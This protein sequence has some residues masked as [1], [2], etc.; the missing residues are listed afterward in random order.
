[1]IVTGLFGQQVPAEN[2]ATV[3]LWAVWLKGVAILSALLGSPWQILSPWRTIYD[4]LTK[5]EGEP[6]SLLDRY[7]DWIGTWPA[8][9]LFLVWIGIVENLTVV[10][11][12]PQLTA[13]FLVVY[14]LVMLGGGLAFGPTWF[15]RADTL[16]VF[17]RLF[18]RIAL[19]DVVAEPDGSL[20]IYF[21]SPWN[22]CTRPVVGIAVA[23]FVIATVYT[24][25]FDG[26]TSAPGF[27]TLLFGIRNA[28]DV[29]SM[30]SIVLYLSGY[31]GFVGA[32]LGIIVLTQ[33]AAGAETAKW[34]LTA[35]AFAPTILPIAVAYEIA[36]N[37]PF[38]I[39]N[40]G[41]LPTVLWPV[42][43]GTGPE[44]DLLTWLTVVVYW[45]SQ[46]ILIVAGHIV[47]VIAAHYVAITG[48]PTTTAAR[49]GHIPLTVLMV[50]YTVLS[51]W[52]ISRPIITG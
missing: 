10:P 26:F 20:R 2:F 19:I 18:G 8:L 35:F 28:L 37:Y 29:S 22:A 16:A 36:H 30:V 14:M 38:V 32:F 52:I 33:W 48:Y 31:A 47:A 51:L 46:V 12:S 4:S 5:L 39:A 1:M 7:S 41:R 23:A 17:Y 42:L 40:L 9:G 21:R 25:S 15:R 3:F 6:I 50:G 43:T 34:R 45:W 24:V 13:F 49:R 27:Q 11:R 44:I